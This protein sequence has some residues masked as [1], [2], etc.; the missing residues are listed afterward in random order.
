MYFV[1]KAFSDFYIRCGVF[2]SQ[3]GAI[4]RLTTAVPVMLALGSL[5]QY[6][7]P[8]RA[9]EVDVPAIFGTSLCP[10][11]LNI[12]LDLT[13]PNG[14]YWRQSVSLIPPTR[15]PNIMNS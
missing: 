9:L 12:V 7:N 10:F 2:K 1:Y 6:S 4:M 11:S 8:P 3:V 15:F 5:Y 13:S 14:G